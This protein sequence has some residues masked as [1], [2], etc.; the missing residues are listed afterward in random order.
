M[1]KLDNAFFRMIIA[2]KWYIDPKYYFVSSV[3]HNIN[4][5]KDYHEPKMK[6]Y[7]LGKPNVKYV[8]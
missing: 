8:K 1:E 6:G 5:W 4:I 7:L 2:N 3:S